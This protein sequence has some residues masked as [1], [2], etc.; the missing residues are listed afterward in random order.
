MS[1][2]TEIGDISTTRRRQRHSRRHREHRTTRTTT[3]EHTSP[4]STPH[5]RS[6]CEKHRQRRAQRTNDRVPGPTLHRRRRRAPIRRPILW[7]DGR[8]SVSDNYDELGDVRL[9]L[10]Y[11]LDDDDRRLDER[12]LEAQAIVTTTTIAPRPPRLSPAGAPCQ[13]H[14]NDAQSTETTT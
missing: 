12:H 13:V 6:L 7:D 9:G 3:N 4:S 8:V 2:L 11:L 5:H 1:A 10:A 14:V